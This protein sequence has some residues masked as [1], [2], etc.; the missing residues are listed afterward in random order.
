MHL[1]KQR[2]RRLCYQVTLV[3]ENAFFHGSLSHPPKGIILSRDQVRYSLEI[4][5][6]Y[7][8]FYTAGALPY[9]VFSVHLRSLVL[10]SSLGVD[11]H[12][13]IPIE[14]AQESSG[15]Q[16][17]CVHVFFPHGMP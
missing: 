6:G 9:S 10:G 8:S 15:I 11:S 12:A 14:F 4:S 17:D 5:Y 13:K 16:Q 3:G 1:R 7:R 2:P